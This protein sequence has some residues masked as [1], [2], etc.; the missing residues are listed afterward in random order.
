M[1]TEAGG[2][3]AVLRGVSPVR[4]RESVMPGVRIMGLAENVV[5]G[6]CLLPNGH[7]AMPGR[8]EKGRLVVRC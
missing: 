8:N 7:Q 1:L 2:I 6:L 3:G 5:T 4:I